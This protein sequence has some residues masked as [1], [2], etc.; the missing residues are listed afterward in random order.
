MT[1][2]RMS[3]DI[4]DANYTFANGATN[5]AV[6]ALGQYA[7]G[8]YQIPA[9]FTG[10]TITVQYSVDGSNWTTVPTEGSETNPQTVTTNGTYR[11]PVMTF[12]AKFMRLVS[13][14]AEGA[15]R[16]VKLYLRS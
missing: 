15:A 16:T 4:F 9:A 7:W 5:G 2:Q 13:G 8:S 11:L 14:T 3:R 10:T 1:G 6:Y 12:A